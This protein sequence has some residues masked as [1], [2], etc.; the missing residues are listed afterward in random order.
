[1]ISIAEMDVVPAN[2][3]DRANKTAK[4]INAI[5]S[6]KATT[7]INVEVTG[8]RAWYCFITIKVAAGAV[9][10]A[11]APRVK[12]TEIGRE[13]PRKMWAIRSAIIVIIAP[14]KASQI[15]MMTTRFPTA[16]S[17]DNLNDV[18]IVKAMN[19][20]AISLIHLTAFNF[21]SSQPPMYWPSTY[22]PKIM[23]AIK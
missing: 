1:M 18:P 6:S 11:M 13:F 22:G 14:P 12:I 16:L 19:P 9:A 21:P 17:D 7:G 8:P 3:L 10:H 15:V 4:V 2:D 5:A 20:R 23:P